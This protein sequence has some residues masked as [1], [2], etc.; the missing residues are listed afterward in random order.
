MRQTSEKTLSPFIADSKI[1]PI[2]R[3]RMLFYLSHLNS[4]LG[5]I[6]WEAFN[7]GRW[8]K[9]IAEQA[10]SFKTYQRTIKSNY[11]S[12]NKFEHEMTDARFRMHDS[13]DFLRSEITD[14]MRSNFFTARLYARFN[15]KLNYHFLIDMNFYD[16]LKTINSLRELRNSFIQH[17][18][19]M[20]P[21]PATRIKH[22]KHSSLIWQDQK[23][24]FYLIGRLLLPFMAHDCI[25]ML[26][27]CYKKFH[28]P[29]HIIDPLKHSVDAAIAQI[30]SGL[31]D[32]I[33][34]SVKFHSETRTREAGTL[35]AEQRRHLVKSE[36]YWQSKYLEFYPDNQNYRKNHRNFINLV[37][38][39]GTSNLNLMQQYFHKYGLTTQMDI[40][41][42]ALNFYILCNRLHA[43]F[44]E[45]LEKIG[46]KRW[47][48]NPV[49]SNIRNE[50]AHNGFFWNSRPNRTGDC[51]TISEIL[52][53]FLTEINKTNGINSLNLFAISL[54]KFLRDEN[55]ILAWQRNPVTRVR[56]PYSPTH[57]KPGAS[58]N[59]K[60]D[61][62]LI[63]YDR[64]PLMRNIAADWNRALTQSYQNI[65]GNNA[66]PE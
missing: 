9:I 27:S 62:S 38:F 33:N 40:E 55:Y 47:K 21:D 15:W 36:Q 16:L 49:L 18:F 53:A 8:Q 60:P 20:K 39:I 57:A 12:Q 44:F 43:L 28:A 54:R 61:T 32:R 14:F 23:N 59:H 30:E 52:T 6:F 24:S 41:F 37:Q 51:Y 17:P 5:N 3:A 31:N 4:Q 26:F 11:D 58:R 46:E 45:A 2:F 34:D 19:E 65:A 42:H 48:V 35:N 13:P 10:K 22:P 56:L 25:D 63:E 7:N 50:I 29:P 66:I 64:R 1:S